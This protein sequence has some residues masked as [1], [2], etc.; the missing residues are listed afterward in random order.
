MTSETTPPGGGS[1][2]RSKRILCQHTAT[3]TWQLQAASPEFIGGQYSRE[4]RWQFDGGVTVPASPSPHVVPAP[5]S[6]ESGVDPEESFVAAICSCHLLTFLW[7]ASQKK[8]VVTSYADT[9]IGFMTRNDEGVPWVSR[10]E[11]HPQIT[12]DNSYQPTA[13]QLAA[14]HHEAHQQ[15]YIANSVRTEIVVADL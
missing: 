2:S 4:H 7:L 9:A 13:E 3:V 1:S 14:L 12:W 8:F 6:N 15:C 5:W 10:V 11:L